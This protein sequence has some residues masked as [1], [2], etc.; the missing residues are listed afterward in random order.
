MILTEEQFFELYEPITNPETEEYSFET[1]GEDLDFIKRTNPLHVWTMLD[2][3]LGNVAIVNG[4]RFVN[5]IC[6][7]VCNKP[8]NPKD[9]IYVKLE[10]FE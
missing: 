9:D 8:F 1:F 3:D 4:T 7:M 6:Y 2:D 10:K 5:R